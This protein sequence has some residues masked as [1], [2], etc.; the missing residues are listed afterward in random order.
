M[1][2]LAFF[3]KND[4]VLGWRT[5][6]I[7][8]PH[9]RLAQ[10]LFG[11][12]LTAFIILLF[13]PASKVSGAM[14]RREAD[15]HPA[16]H[17]VAQEE[18]Q[19]PILASLDSCLAES[20][21]EGRA[22]CFFREA[23]VG[24]QDP[25]YLNHWTGK[26]ADGFDSLEC[27]ETPPGKILDTFF[28]SFTVL[29]KFHSL[30]GAAKAH[31]GPKGAR[32]LVRSQGA[33]G[34]PVND[35]N[36][37]ST[38]GIFFNKTA[39]DYLCGLKKPDS[40]QPVT[41]T[42]ASQALPLAQQPAA[43]SNF[44]AGSI[45]VKP[46]WYLVPEDPVREQIHV[47]AGADRSFPPDA[48]TG[49]KI[50]NWASVITINNENQDNCNFKFKSWRSGW[51]NIPLACF[52]WKHFDQAQCQQMAQERG[53]QITQPDQNAP[54]PAGC[55]LLLMALNISAKVGKSW[56]FQTYWWSTRGQDEESQWQVKP[57]SSDKKWQFFVMRTGSTD[58][59]NPYLEGSFAG[60]TTTNCT[61]C[62]QKA[63][64][65]S[66]KPAN[67]ALVRCLFYE[68]SNVPDL[69]GTTRP[70]ATDGKNI[71]RLTTD[72]VWSLAETN[73]VLNNQIANTR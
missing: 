54:P 60:G 42:L 43:S 38:S 36:P 55:Y 33:A 19:S 4:E 16:D 73:V 26:P 24:L 7:Q 15:A 5:G 69:S 66:L 61:T 47:W 41:D 48:Q 20:T 8:I 57:P 62:H 30:V 25:Q 56:T 2:G 39:K 59:Y 53:T 23:A 58:F 12:I 44:P 10:V 11:A 13:I 3:F 32:T 51:G 71:R 22:N 14:K 35:G 45:F 17:G 63:E 27:T 72:S 40:D 70:C 34:I 46:F 37:L 28:A 68:H 64:F 29:T 67:R 9:R 18:P 31:S 50:P 6:M 1:A 52:F 21:D 49:T 65:D